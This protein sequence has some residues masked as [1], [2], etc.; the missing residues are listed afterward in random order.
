[1]NA[2]ALAEAA[3]FVR[4]FNM[5][6]GTRLPNGSWAITKHADAFLVV[7]NGYLAHEEYW[8]STTN[9]TMHELE[10]GTKSIS[11]ILLAH[12]VK[13]GLLSTE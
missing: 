7:K 11:S 9:K 6:G 10:S 3:N 8:G 1:M 13:L 12:A 5:G 2:S 4:L